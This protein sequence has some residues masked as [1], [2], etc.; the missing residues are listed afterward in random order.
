[1]PAYRHLGTL[2]TPDLKLD[3][4][5][6]ARIGMASSAFAQLSRRLLTNR[7]LPCKL[8]I[9]LFHSLVLSKL[10]FSAGSWHTPTGRQLDGLRSVVVRMLRKI[11]GHQPLKRQAASSV[12]AQA[13]VFDPRV[14][15]AIDRL[16][17]AQR[18]FH[19]GPAYLQ[20]M[21]HE[22]ARTC[23]HSWG[24]K[25]RIHRAGRRHLLQEAITLQAQD[26][27]AKIFRVL[28]DHAF[29]FAPDPALLHLQ[30]DG[31]TPLQDRW[32]EILCNPPVDFESW[33]TRTFLAWGQHILPDYVATLFDG[34][35]EALID[36]AYA[37]FACELHEYRLQQRLNCLEQKIA[38]LTEDEDV[39]HRAPRA[40]THTGGPH[41]TPAHEVVRLFAEQTEW[42]SDL[43][44]V[45]WQDLPPDPLTP[46]VPSLAPRP[47]FIIVHLFSGRRRALDISTTIWP[48]GRRSAT[49]Q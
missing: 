28:R 34:V 31:V 15:L 37:D 41:S 3:A 45:R 46:V 44:K 49:F 26:G 20:L 43:E 42:H 32:I 18:L 9:Q 40:V 7:H 35:A 22:E 27:H 29:T 17:Y 21:I 12:L 10:Y 16:L 48:S 13:E 23:S 33:A 19:H 8:R 11:L 25:R 39:P 2:Y 6:A 30:E 5:I 38:R 14:R 24:W 4:E 47:S 1:M 36:E